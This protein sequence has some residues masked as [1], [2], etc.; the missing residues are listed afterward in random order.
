MKQALG[1]S[2]FTLRELLM[3]TAIIGTLASVAI[4]SYQQFSQRARFSAAILAATP[5]RTAIEV[6]AFR[7]NVSSVADFDW[8]THGIPNIQWGGA[9]TPW[10]IPINGIIYVLWQFD[11][12]PLSGVSYILE[13]Q[14][15]IPPI[16][17][18]QY[19]SCMDLGYC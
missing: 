3:V 4:P 19:G 18:E 15:H 7:G 1:Q 12:S 13:A 11:G 10:I 14:N 8:S 16:R 5:Y 2:G 6:A 17:W 9:N